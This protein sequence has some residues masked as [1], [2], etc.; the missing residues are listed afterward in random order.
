MVADRF[1]RVNGDVHR[2]HDRTCA[3]RFAGGFNAADLED[4]EEIGD[5]E[6][7]A[8]RAGV[9]APRTFNKN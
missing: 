1:D 3:V 2:A 5:A 4:A 9:F 8:V 7:R 6:D